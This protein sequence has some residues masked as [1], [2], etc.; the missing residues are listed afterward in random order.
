MKDA[1][2]AAPRV[3]VVSEERQICGIASFLRIF[4]EMEEAGETRRNITGEAEGP[5]FSRAVYEC[6]IRMG[7]DRSESDA[8]T[9]P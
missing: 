2:T 7:M 9:H 1:E 3:P 4:Q 5:F 6:V 8:S